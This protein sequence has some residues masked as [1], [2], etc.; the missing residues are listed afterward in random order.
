MTDRNERGDVAAG[1][2]IVMGAAGQ[3]NVGGGASHLHHGHYIIECF[4]PDGT[5]KWRDEIENLVVNTGLDDIL[6]KY[7]KGATYTASHF[8]GLT[9]GSPTIAAGDTMASHAG[10][11]EVVAYSEGVRQT[12]TLGA[13]AS[14]SVDN[15]ASVGVFSISGTATVGGLFLTTNNVKGGATGT[16]VSVGAFTG[17][18]RLVASGDTINTTVTNSASAV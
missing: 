4:R 15:S 13:V 12:L 2:G 6:D 16:L 14:Q 3:T 17:G 7:W 18:D 11:T 10:W 1:H 5:L 9:D 8:I